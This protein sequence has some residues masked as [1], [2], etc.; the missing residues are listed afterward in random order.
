MYRNQL[1]VV[2]RDIAAAGGAESSPK[3][4]RNVAETSG[5]CVLR[6]VAGLLVERRTTLRALLQFDR[7]LV[8][9]WR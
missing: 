1:A 2:L 7:R 8:V 9:G 4:R 6:P 3:R 5:A